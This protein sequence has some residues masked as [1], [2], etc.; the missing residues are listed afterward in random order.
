MEFLTVRVLAFPS[1]DHNVGFFTVIASHDAGNL[2]AVLESG[3]TNRTG[4]FLPITQDEKHHAFC[5]A[6]RTPVR[7]P[8]DTRRRQRTAL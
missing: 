8:A 7:L 4:R 6:E 1:F 5:A 3:A 2:I